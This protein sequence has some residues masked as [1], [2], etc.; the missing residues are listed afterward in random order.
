MHTS[1]WMICVLSSWM[2]LKA[3][4]QTTTSMQDDSPIHSSHLVQDWI[5]KHSP[6]FVMKDEPWL[7]NSPD[8]NSLDYH[9][10]STMFERYQVFTPKPT[11]TAE[12]K[13]ALEAICEDFLK[14]LSTWLCKH[15]GRGYTHSL[16]KMK[17][18]LNAYSNKIGSINKWLHSG[19]KISS[20]VMIRW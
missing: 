10:W 16:K 12:L 15:S 2:T 8:L 6:E 20:N 18:T 14:R 5:E 13:T 17:V 4:C 3:W 9:A 7:L 19:P 11:N 1:T